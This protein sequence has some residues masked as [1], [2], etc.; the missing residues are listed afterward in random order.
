MNVRNEKLVVGVWKSKGFL[1][2]IR[3]AYDLI[4]SAIIKQLFWRFLCGAEI[5][6]RLTLHHNNTSAG[7]AKSCSQQCFTKLWHPKQRDTIMKNCT[8]QNI[9]IVYINLSLIILY[10]LLGAWCINWLT[11]TFEGNTVA[12]GL[13]LWWQKSAA[14]RNYTH[15]HNYAWQ[16][17]KKLPND[18]GNITGLTNF[19]PSTSYLAK[20]PALTLPPYFPVD[21]VNSRQK[22]RTSV[23]LIIAQ[24]QHACLHL[25]TPG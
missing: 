21:P 22:H 14:A 4:Y 10:L 2:L 25:S 9:G 5:F 19:Q 15:S 17:W 24:W 7:K 12:G 11:L 18:P 8:G 1:D 16:N 13:C 6:W 3:K 20:V 23:T